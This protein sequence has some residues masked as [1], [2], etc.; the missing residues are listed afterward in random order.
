MTRVKKDYMKKLLSVGMAACLSLIAAASF[1]GCAG[2]KYERSTGEYI[3]DKAISSRVKSALADNE[4]YKF[5]DVEVKSFKGTV[6]LAGFVNSADQKGKAGDIAEK[7]EGV[8]EVVNN[9]TVKQ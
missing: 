9:I 2:N 6:Q 7:V 8:R 5:G 3:D 4:Q 1:T